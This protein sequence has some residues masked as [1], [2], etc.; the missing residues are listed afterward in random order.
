MKI[1]AV[2]HFACSHCRASLD[3]VIA[4]SKEVSGSTEVITGELKCNSCHHSYAITRGV[5]RFVEA[6]QTTPQNLE[7]GERFGVA[8]HEF[9]RM[10]ARYERQF[11]DWVF[12]VGPE[13]FKGKVILEAGCGKG[14]HAEIVS[15]CGADAIFAIDIGPAADIAY[16]NVGH[17]PN[18]HIVQC[19]ILNLPFKPE[20]DAAFS[21]GV[22][23]HIDEPGRGFGSLCKILKPDGSIFVWVYGEEN[24]W[25]LIKI[26]NPIRTAI[27]TK[28]PPAPLKLLSFLLAVPVFLY[29]RF[30]AKPY[31]DWRRRFRW[32]PELF[33]GEYLAYISRFDFNEIHHIVFD[34]LVAP[35]S[36][37]INRSEVERWYREEGLADPVIRWHNRNSWT[38]FGSR[39]PL[40]VTQMK[41]RML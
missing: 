18:V 1:E 13:F 14:R 26:I 33:Y 36:H 16:H 6:E 17:M 11:F 30:F 2:P 39:Q 10:D 8:W 7:T 12:P 23:H 15:R 32:M 37:Y 22:L 35:V 3:L 19:D 25:W 29:A 5:P 40:L 38:G 41:D 27:T 28:L 21:V 31:K 4:E 24:N 9:S 20:F 34:H